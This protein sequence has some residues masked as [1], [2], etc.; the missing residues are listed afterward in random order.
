[1]TLASIYFTRICRAKSFTAAK[2][3][4]EQATE[5]IAVSYGELQALIGASRALFPDHRWA[6][7]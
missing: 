7:W 4:M 5:D 6:E 1:M 3:I 2:A